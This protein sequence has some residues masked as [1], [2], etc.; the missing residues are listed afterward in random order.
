MKFSIDS[1]DSLLSDKLIE[2]M[3][4]QLTG[5]FT[6][7]LVEQRLQDS[8]VE[9][10]ESNQA[11]SFFDENS[12]TQFSKEMHNTAVDKLTG[13][14]SKNTGQF[15]SIE[16]A[17]EKSVGQS[18][19]FPAEKAKDSRSLPTKQTSPARQNLKTE[20][21][22]HSKSQDKYAFSEVKRKLNRSSNSISGEASSNAKSLAASGTSKNAKIPPPAKLINKRKLSINELSALT[23]QAELKRRAAMMNRSY[24]W[25]GKTFGPNNDTKAYQNTDASFAVMSQQKKLESKQVEYSKTPKNHRSSATNPDKIPSNNSFSHA[26]KL[27]PMLAPESKNIKG[28]EAALKRPIDQLIHEKINKVQ[29]AASQ[30]NKS[31]EPS[32]RGQLDEHNSLA[33]A[34]NTIKT[35]STFE[36]S[37]FG[38]LK[39]LAALGNAQ[40]SS[41]SNSSSSDSNQNNQAAGVSKVTQLPTL[42]SNANINGSGIPSAGSSQTTTASSIAK[43]LAD[44]ARRAG[45]DLEKFQP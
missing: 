40:G 9:S 11:L 29:S 44:E 41:Q 38:G 19:D 3:W 15:A 26:N 12:F 2:Q 16:H 7:L 34:K 24:E 4:L 1:F 42:N 32:I 35:P 13:K 10:L 6:A 5:G 18:I 22:K 25:S 17:L 27:S 33:P 23:A 37:G 28:N 21:G 14:A 39:G 30:F 45:I 20:Q 31:N 36:R 43:L 8:S